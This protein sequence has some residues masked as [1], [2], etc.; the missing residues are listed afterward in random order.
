[1]PSPE[2]AGQPPDAD[3]P[4]APDGAAP[5]PVPAEATADADT[6]PPAPAENGAKTMETETAENAEDETKEADGNLEPVAL[7]CPEIK[8]ICTLHVGKKHIKL[9]KWTKHEQMI[10]Y[11]HI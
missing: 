1:M 7:R 10:I 5:E 8:V 11:I 9:K 3:A 4:D 2:G 6:A